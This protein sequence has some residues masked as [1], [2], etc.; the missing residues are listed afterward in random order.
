MFAVSD[1]AAAGGRP[2]DRGGACRAP[3]G[4][5]RSRPDPC[6]HGLS[7]CEVAA[8]LSRARQ[9]GH[10]TAR[11][12]A[13]DEADSFV[14]LPTLEAKATACQIGKVQHTPAAIWGR[15]TLQMG[16]LTLFRGFMSLTVAHQPELRGV[17][18]LAAWRLM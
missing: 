8:F 12:L 10:D 9:L 13:G 7:A 2:S 17:L 14:H 4:S 1:P 18:S 3:D 6:G 15:G 16:R 11:L 5:D